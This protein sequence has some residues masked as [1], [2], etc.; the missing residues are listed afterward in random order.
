MNPPFAPAATTLLGNAHGI[1]RIEAWLKAPRA[2]HDGDEYANQLHYLQALDECAATLRQ[3][4]SILDALHRRLH[5]VLDGTATTLATAPLPLPRK[6]KLTLRAAQ[7]CLLNLAGALLGC[8]NSIDAHL[9]RGLGYPPELLLWRAL[10]SLRRHFQLSTQVAA[11]AGH[12]LWRELHPGVRH[13]TPIFA[14]FRKVPS[15]LARV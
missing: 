8:L 13:F 7:D 9:V 15:A 3:R 14:P 4:L 2:A 10:S 6:Q 11:P 12:N 1:A 5:A